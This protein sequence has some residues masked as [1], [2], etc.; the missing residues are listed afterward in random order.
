MLSEM[1]VMG[2]LPGEVDLDKI[3]VD[4][5]S[6]PVLGE[7]TTNAALVLAAASRKKPRELGESLK[8]RLEAAAIVT[9]VEVAGPGFINIHLTP[10]VWYQELERILQL[11]TAYGDSVLG[12]NERINI[13]YVSANPTGP[14]HIAHARG[15]VYGDVLANLLD[16]VGFEVAREFYINDTGNQIESLCHSIYHHYLQAAGETTS[17]P[18]DYPGKYIEELGRT[19]FKRDGTQWR[20]VSQALW[21]PVVRQMA[22]EHIMEEI[23]HDLDLLGVQFQ[24]YRSESEV[25]G[26]GRLEEALEILEQADCLYTGVLGPPLGKPSEDW[27]ERPQRLFR[28]TRFGDEVDRPLTKPDGAG[29]YFAHD[30]A[31]HL[32]KFRRGFHRLINVWGADHGGYVKRLKAAVEVVSDSQALLEIQLCQMVHLLEEGKPIKMSKRLGQFVSLKQ[33]LSEVSGDVVR[34]IMLTRRHDQ[35]LEFDFAQ[36]TRDSQDNPVFYVQYAHARCC[37]VLRYAQTLFGSARLEDLSPYL[38]KLTAPEELI[39]IR[40]MARWPKVVESTARSYELQ[41]LTSYLQTLAGAFHELWTK[42]KTNTTL[43]FLIPQEPE[44]TLARVALIKGIS[45][46]IASGLKVMGIVPVQE[47]KN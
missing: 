40:L 15:A 27:Q 3:T 47:L 2:E 24:V 17:A 5:P 21:Y 29:T 18:V 12:G 22:L 44:I 19:L 30:I 38:N 34:F 8:Q 14:I 7:L 4:L 6:E 33:L 42:G 16:K 46:V 31:Y 41:R 20:A 37:S 32:D 10:E 23:R 36:V 35:V 26:S 13:E 9:K 43:R 25:V 39:L 45:T 28:S 11:G 1:I